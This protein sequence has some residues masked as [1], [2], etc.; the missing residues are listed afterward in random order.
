MNAFALCTIAPGAPDISVTQTE[1]A[2]TELSWELKCK[3]G[4]MKAYHVTYYREDDTSDKKTLTTHAKETKVRIEK[5]EPGKTF[6]FQVRS[7]FVTFTRE[8]AKRNER[9]IA[10]GDK[11]ANFYF[12]PFFLPSFLGLQMFIGN[13]ASAAFYPFQ[14][15]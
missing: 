6:V 12:F 1:D 3:N 15:Q 2:S 9:V 5:L 7:A 4:I 11:Y 8:Y 14:M 13:S 10:D